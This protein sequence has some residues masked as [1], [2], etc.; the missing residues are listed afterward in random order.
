MK[1]TRLLLVD[2]DPLVR[3]SLRL[4]LELYDLP[5]VGEAADGEEALAAVIK[6]QPTLVLMDINMPVMDGIQAAKAIIQK[7]PHVKIIILTVH[8]Q[9]DK[10]IQAIRAGCSG[11]VLKD[12]AVEQL[13]GVIAY[14]VNGE[15]YID[16]RIANDL[17]VHLLQKNS[18]R[19]PQRDKASLT[20]REKEVLQLIVN[21]LS[22]KEIVSRLKIT[23]RT[24]KAHISSILMKL[25]V[26]DRTQAAILAIQGGLVDPDQYP[27]GKLS[28]EVQPG[29]T[30]WY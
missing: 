8:N 6:Y 15:Y 27:G 30:R 3:R 21:G 18:A 4:I 23:L 24:V 11:Y 1:E 12:S 14:V 20:M 29:Q 22:N 7:H 26:N 5:V 10:V 9:Y 28:P 25:N 17:L 19:Q 2:D 13:V 16:P